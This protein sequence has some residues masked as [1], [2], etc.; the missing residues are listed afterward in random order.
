MPHFLWENRRM[1]TEATEDT[2]LIRTERLCKK[3]KGIT[4]LE[5]LSFTLKRGEILGLLGPNGA[6]KTTAINIALGL[7]APTAGHVSVFGL[8]PEKN[9]PRL[10]HRLNFSSAYAN[11]PSNLKVMENLMLFARLYGIPRKKEKIRS[12]LETFEVLH[13]ENCLTGTLSSGEKTRINLVKSFLNDPQLLILDEPTA[14]LDPDISDKVRKTLKTLQQKN[15]IG[16]LYTSHNM[17]EVEE[18]CDRIIFINRGKTI[19]EGT[20]GQ[21][22]KLFSTESLEQAFIKIVRSGD[23]I[24]EQNR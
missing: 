18:I 21:I 12:L 9:R 17:L 23:L 14:S 15:R 4:A 7:L 6:G 10:A 2:C 8:A 3:F 16:I 20:S 5:A 11:L 19:A 1:T 13:L 22:Q 24:A